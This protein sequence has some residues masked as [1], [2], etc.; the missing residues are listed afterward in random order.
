MIRGLTQFKERHDF[1]YMTSKWNP[2]E[3]GIKNRTLETNDGQDPLAVETLLVLRAGMVAAHPANW[4]FLPIFLLGAEVN[5]G[6]NFG[7]QACSRRKADQNA[8]VELLPQN[9]TGLF[10]PPPKLQDSYCCS[11]W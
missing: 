5:L 1:M 4:A 8:R 7:D 6:E 11:G 2:G 9:L 3:Q 10:L